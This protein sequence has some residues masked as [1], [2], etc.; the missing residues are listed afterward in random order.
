MKF[1]KMRETALS[2]S[3]TCMQVSGLLALAPMIAFDKLGIRG[4]GSG[5]GPAMAA[6]AIGFLIMLPVTGPL[7]LAGI[8]IGKAFVVQPIRDELMTKRKD[9]PLRK[10][11]A[12]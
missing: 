4:G 9:A 7:M 10:L 8:L 1:R 5:M 3:D 11:S 12:V 6:W 2:V